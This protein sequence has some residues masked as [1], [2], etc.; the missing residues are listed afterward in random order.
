[1]LT[2]RPSHRVEAAETA[3]RTLGRYNQ[4]NPQSFGAK[5][6]QTVVACRSAIR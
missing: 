2:P 1:M 4:H 3:F 5:H 6:G